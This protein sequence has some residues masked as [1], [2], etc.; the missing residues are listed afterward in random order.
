MCFGVQRSIVAGNSPP[1]MAVC[2][3]LLVGRGK[4]HAISE[5]E[6]DSL[7]L[8]KGFFGGIPH[9]TQPRAAVGSG[10]D[11]YGQTSGP[12]T[13]SYERG[14]VPVMLFLSCRLSRWDY[15]MITV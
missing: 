6:L 11:C 5:K 12:V 3:I 2:A 7:S 8:E 15:H 9:W 4:R 10:R 13:L 1:L 14:T